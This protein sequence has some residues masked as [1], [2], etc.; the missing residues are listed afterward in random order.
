M[1]WAVIQA[2]MKGEKPSSN[3]NRSHKSYLGTTLKKASL[4][5]R[6]IFLDQ[7]E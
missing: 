1:N 6:K 7:Q 5:F 4:I 2:L 3:R